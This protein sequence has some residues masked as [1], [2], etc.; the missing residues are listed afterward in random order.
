MTPAQR[1]TE[2]P[3][4]PQ[5]AHRTIDKALNLMGEEFRKMRSKEEQR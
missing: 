5:K 3:P 1:P 2:T 4:I